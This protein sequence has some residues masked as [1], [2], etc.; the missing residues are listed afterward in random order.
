MMMIKVIKII[1]MIVKIIFNKYFPP[2]LFW[3]VLLF[4]LLH[5]YFVDSTVFE[6]SMIICLTL[7]GMKVFNPNDH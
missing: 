6:E 4:T 3:M 2:T 5:L 1:E 7:L